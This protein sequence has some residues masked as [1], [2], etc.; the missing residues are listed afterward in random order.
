MLQDTIKNRTIFYRDNIDIL[1][2]INSN[3][4]DLIYLDP[5]FN[6]NDTFITQNNK[7]IEKIKNFFVELQKQGNFKNEDFNEIFKDNTVA[8]DDIWN[9]NDIQKEYYSQ[10]DKYNH[11]LIDYLNSIQKSTI[12]GTF[13]YLL[14][15]SIRLIELHRILKDTGSL[16]LHC[17]NTMSHYLKGVLDKIFDYK[18]FR[19]EIVWCYRGAGYPKKDFGKRHDIIYRYSNSNDYIFNVDNVREE[20]AFSTRERFKYY[21][22]NKRK[23][24]DFG[25]QQLNQKGKHPDD[26]WQIQPIAPSSK[27]RVGYPTQKPLAL[28]ERII[29]ASSNEGDMVLDPFCGCATTC[30]ASE[31]LNRR[32]IGIDWNIQSYYMVYYRYIQDSLAGKNNSVFKSKKEIINKEIRRLKNQNPYLNQEKE[33][34][35]RKELDS[36][37]TEIKQNNIEF[38]NLEKNI[39]LLKDI[40]NRTDL[41]SNEKKE[42]E[43]SLFNLGKKKEIKQSK[44][45]LSLEEKKIAKEL[46]YED[47][48]G[49]CNGCDAFMRKADLTLDHI[50]PKS[51][52]ESIENLQLLCYRCNNWKRTH[53]MIY[54]VNRLKEES[55]ISTVTYNKQ[56]KRYEKINTL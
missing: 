33:E 56:I 48:A 36:S 11:Y 14:F 43:L 29:K 55:I 37:K 12:R 26:W 2:G 31:K 21:I 44:K 20:Y 41:T 22:G 32:W 30:I 35:L 49:I 15:M 6:K 3:S 38:A 46:L 5:P 27:E 4:V 42:L 34:K 51:N 52:E 50:I 45:K 9:E 7:N 23:G 1:K 53:N 39:I 24:L 25:E 10:L 16:Y 47:Q 40:P 18:N 8:F 17:D 13:Y 19:N 54:L 28:L